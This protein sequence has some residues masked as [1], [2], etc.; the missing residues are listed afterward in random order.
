VTVSGW[1]GWLLRRLVVAPL[2][3]VLAVVVAALWV[4][5][6]LGSSVTGAARALAGRGRPR[7]RAVRVATF[8]LLYLLGETACLLACLGL[9]VASG[10]GW[11]LHGGWF[12]RAHRA[13][14]AAFLGILVRAASV[15]FGFRLVVEEPR[16]HP[17]DLL[18]AERQE[19]V[20]VLAR[21]AGPGASFVLVH[22]L[23]S[24][25][26]RLP[27]VVL[28]EQLRL[29]PAVDLL[30][31][32][33]GCTWVPSG[34][35]HGANAAELIG[36]AAGALVGRQAL[37]LYPEGADWTPV[38]HLQAVARL[39]GR[40]RFREAR[41]ALRMPHVLPPRPAGTVA[42]LQAAPDADVLVF[43]HT[44]HDQLLDAAST[45][46]ALPLR[47]PLRMTWWCARGQTVPRGDEAAVTDWLHHTWVDIDAWVEEQQALALA[48][49]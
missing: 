43:T 11:R 29:D 33:T 25:Y 37:V 14:L 35:D 31:T 32:R 40:G 7:W 44:G 9:W 39:R 22:L 3:P 2:M 49:S 19:P 13:V 17:E 8:A 47:D 20:L 18:W 38:R 34:R 10:L 1:A 27:Q 24:R 5:V 45:W 12:V 16:R 6:L 42:A 4:P 28:K 41:D 21:H 46:R 26:Q 23:I 36:S 30:L 15:V 48:Q